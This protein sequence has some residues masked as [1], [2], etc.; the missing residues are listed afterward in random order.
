[1]VA[2]GGLG[3][4]HGREATYA[5]IAYRVGFVAVK[6]AVQA[7]Q[8]VASIYRDFGDR[9]NRK[10]ARLKYLIG[11][12]G[13]EW[14][15]EEFKKRADF[16]LHESKEIPDVENEDWLGVYKQDDEKFFYGVFVENGR[17]DDNDK[18]KCKSAFKKIVTELGC[19]VTFT[20]QQSLLFTGLS[21]SDVTRLEEILAE[22]DVAKVDQ[23]SNALRYSMACPAMPTCGLAVAESERAMPDVVRELGAK[24]ESMGLGDVKL[25]VRMTGCPNAVSYT[26]LTL[27]TKRIV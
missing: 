27:P 14:F 10:H 2:G 18:T 7:I 12:K 8:N 4:S 16:D 19:G 15:Q 3:M 21:E 6:D 23:L 5:Q 22:F 13:I 26:H 11:D 20:A 24:L 9:N 17:I 25:T 1:M